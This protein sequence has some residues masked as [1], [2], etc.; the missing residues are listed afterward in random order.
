MNHPEHL[1]AYMLELMY[2]LNNEVGQGHHEERQAQLAARNDPLRLAHDEILDNLQHALDSL[3]AFQNT[4]NGR[5]TAQS[6]AEDFV[7]PLYR[8]LQKIKEDYNNLDDEAAMIQDVRAI[9]LFKLEG[10]QV[11]WHRSGPDAAQKAL[12]AEAMHYISLVKK[13][14]KF[15]RKCRAGGDCSAEGRAAAH[16]SHF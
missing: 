14:A 5:F 13:D 1:E 11:A 9:D 10:A 15:L 7:Q 12:W 3:Q 16:A 8:I 2:A 4:V 6:F